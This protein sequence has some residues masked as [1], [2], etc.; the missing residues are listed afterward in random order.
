MSAW[1]DV[2]EQLVKE[3]GRALFG[4]AYVLTGDRHEADDLLQDALVRAFKS[5][6]NVRSIDAAHAYVKKAIASAFV[7]RGRRAA[8]R[9]RYAEA[10]IDDLLS[11]STA[12]VVDH[13]LASDAAFDLQAAVLTLAPRERACVVLRYMEDLRVDEIAAVLGVAPGTVKRYLHEAIQRLRAIMPELEFDD[14]D[15]MDVQA[16][17]GGVR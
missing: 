6:R 17:Q 11:G 4:Y 7:D 9:P 1:R 14:G 16:R 8:A 5:G 15:L 2:L 13:A 10:G 12:P 3:R